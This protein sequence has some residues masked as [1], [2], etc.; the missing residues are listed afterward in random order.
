MKDLM[1][2]MGKLQEMQTK[3]TEVQDEIALIEVSGTAGAGMVTVTLSGK[4]ELRG[5]KIDPT[6]MN[7]NETEMLE[8][9]IMAAHTDAKAKAETAMNDK[10]QEVTAGMPLPPGMKL[11]F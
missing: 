8:D 3:M 11:P 7:P 6:L 9:L 2:M 10:M 4:G 5:L 1:G